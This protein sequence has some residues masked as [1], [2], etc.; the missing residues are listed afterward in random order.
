M[1]IQFDTSAKVI[2][3]NKYNISCMSGDINM[4]STII[5]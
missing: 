5:Q 4:A 2:V 3:F 1:S